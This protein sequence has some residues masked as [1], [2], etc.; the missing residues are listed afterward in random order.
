MSTG[1]LIGISNSDD[2]LEFDA[3]EKLVLYYRPNKQ[4]IIYGAMSLRK[5]D[6]TLHKTVFINREYLHEEN[7][8]HPACFVS[9][10]TYDAIGLYGEKYR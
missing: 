4:Q 1:E 9:K 10:S 2:W 8:P 5:V 6:G 3:V 7:L